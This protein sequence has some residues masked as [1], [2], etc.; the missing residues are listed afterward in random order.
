MKAPSAGNLEL[1]KLS[2]IEPEE[3]F[4]S[5]SLLY[6]VNQKKVKNISPVLRKPEEGFTN[7]SPVLRKPEAGFTNI[8]PVRRKPEAGFTNMS[9]VL[10]KPEAGFANMSPVLCKP[11]AGF[12]S[13][14]PVLRPPP[15][16]P[17]CY[18][19]LLFLPSLFIRLRLLFPTHPPI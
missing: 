2:P 17:L 19:F 13:I 11:E 9:P 4:T 18:F 10:R 7:I 16:I 12:T 1:S 5:I 6:F 15:E 14:P 8:S 3:G